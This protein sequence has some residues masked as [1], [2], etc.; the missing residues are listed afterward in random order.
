MSTQKNKSLSRVWLIAKREIVTRTATKSFLITT[1]LLMVVIIAG[2]VVLA[3]LQG[4]DSDDAERVGLTVGHPGLAQTIEAA[5][6]ATGTTIEIVDADSEQAA[7]DLVASGDVTGAVLIGTDPQ[8]YNLVSD[9]GWNTSVES[10]VRAGIEQFVFV[11]GLAAEGVDAASLPTAT[12]TS[13][14]LTESNPETG[15]RI[16]F[17]LV[18]LVLTSMAI[19]IGGTMVATGVV[20]EKTSRVV[21]ILLATVTPLQLLWGKI[22]GIGMVAL[23]QV[24]VLG[25]TAL[26]AGT[27]SG[28]LTIG[29]AAAGLF[30]AVVAWFLL[31]YLFFATLF[32]AT[33]S[34]VSRQEEVGSSTAPLSIL[35]MGMIY[36][37]AFGIQALDS[38]FMQVITWIPPF[39]AA[40]MPIRIATG[41]TNTA[42]IVGTFAIMIVT[43]AAATWVASRIYQRSVLR[44]GAR[45]KWAEA[46]K[47]SSS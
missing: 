19:M 36:S 38:T 46:L 34:M 22:L 6:E 23:A 16:V 41:D 9:T 33:G 29:G 15:Q 43:C 26:I 35:A 32:A 4:R 5:G 3:I 24:L 28:L 45:V 1:A 30:A 12:I 42:Q 11:E 31:G 13:D 40:L 21:E 14:Q 37:G 10:T 18:G 17:A 27:A 44:T 7:R 47:M 8:T 2:V 25:G 20:E 39:S